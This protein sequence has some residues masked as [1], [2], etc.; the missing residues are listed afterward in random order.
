MKKWEGI[1]DR[2]VTDA[3]GDGDVSHLSGAGKKL[4]LKTDSHTPAECRAAFKIMEDHNVMPDW[5]ATGER[6]EQ[7]AVA[8]Q[9]RI[10]RAARH[11]QRELRQ[12]RTQPKSVMREIVESNW[13]RDA[14]DC[15]KAVQR[16]NRDAL[17]YNLTLPSGIPHRR[18]LQG[19]TLI[20]QALGN[21][22]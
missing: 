22:C 20:E 16:Y 5:I 18:L 17:V 9:E 2:L 14:K 10:R 8:L 7:A 21:D 13:N 11:Y 6:L 15:L 12:A 3:I 1:V 19:E 4:S